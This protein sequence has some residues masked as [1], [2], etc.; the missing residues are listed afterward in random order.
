MGKSEW[1]GSFFLSGIFE[2]EA[3]AIVGKAGAAIDFFSKASPRCAYQW[4]NT[5]KMFHKA[6]F[7]KN[8]P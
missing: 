2:R 8:I 7:G 4:P 5:V 3:G 1:C 6:N